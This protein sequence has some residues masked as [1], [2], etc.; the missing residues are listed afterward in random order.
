MAHSGTDKN[1]NHA[2]LAVHAHLIYHVI[3]VTQDGLNIINLLPL[4]ESQ[5]Q[6]GLIRI[7]VNNAQIFQLLVANPVLSSTLP[8][9]LQLTPMDLKLWDSEITAV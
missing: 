3:P 9:A 5:I 7:I 6:I 8:N 2:P 1:A 4:M